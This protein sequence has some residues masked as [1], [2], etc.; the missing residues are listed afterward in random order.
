[1]T[2]KVRA[3]TTYP[4]PKTISQTHEGQSLQSQI[5]LL[6]QLLTAYRQGTL[7]QR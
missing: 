1:M 2:P 3:L 7:R 5:N 6:D 4:T